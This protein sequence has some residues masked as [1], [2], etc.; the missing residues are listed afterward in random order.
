MKTRVA[1]SI[2]LIR[3]FLIT[4]KRSYTPSHLASCLVAGELLPQLG[5]GDGGPQA[6]VIAARYHL[7]AYRVGGDGHVASVYLPVG[8]LP[9]NPQ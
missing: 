1:A 5:H 6:D 2:T 3:T 7:S 8:A 9:V 4:G